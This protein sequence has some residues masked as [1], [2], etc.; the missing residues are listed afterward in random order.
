MQYILSFVFLIAAF[1]SDS[2]LTISLFS[3]CNCINAFPPLS[4]HVLLLAAILN[5]SF[6]QNFPITAKHCTQTVIPINPVKL[7]LLKLV[8]TFKL[9]KCSL[10]L[11]SLILLCV[12]PL[13]IDSSHFHRCFFLF[14]FLASCLPF[15]IVHSCFSICHVN[16]NVSKGSILTLPSF[17]LC[18]RQSLPR[19]FSLISG[20]VPKLLFPAQTSPQ[21]KAQ[22]FNLLTEHFHHGVFQTPQTQYVQI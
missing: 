5:L 1:P 17:Y 11:V 21:C 10:V 19:N 2:V 9:P 4:C 12:L 6:V 20:E 8:T 22:F 14:F 16:I 7:F 15:V 13:A 3:T 18:F